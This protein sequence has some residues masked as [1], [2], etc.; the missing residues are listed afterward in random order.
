[1]LTFVQYNPTIEDLF[2]KQ[3]RIDNKVCMLEILDTGGDDDFRTLRSQW[4]REHKAV[5]LVYSTSC[6]SSFRR[7]RPLYKEIQ[8]VKGTSSVSLL[9]V[10]NKCEQPD[11]KVSTH[12][13]EALAQEL[14]CEFVETSAKDGTNVQKAFEDAVQKLHQLREATDKAVTEGGRALQPRELNL[15]VFGRISRWI[16]MGVF[17]ACICGRRR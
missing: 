4:I 12:D 14:S 5:M 3:L 6:E 11:R 13:G 9:L 7:I 17:G 8:A 10:G 16:H 15:S 2:R 1:M